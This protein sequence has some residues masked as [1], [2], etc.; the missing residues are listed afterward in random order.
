[1]SMQLLG[2]T[3]EEQIAF[4]IS[5]GLYSKDECQNKIDKFYKSVA[6]ISADIQFASNGRVK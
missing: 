1:M 5:I 4:Y 2:Y 6:K 3:P